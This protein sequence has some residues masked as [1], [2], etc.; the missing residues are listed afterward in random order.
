VSRLELP[1]SGL[2]VLSRLVCRAT[3][4]GRTTV[5]FRLVQPDAPRPMV[6]VPYRLAKDGGTLPG[7]PVFDLQPEHCH[8]EVVLDVMQGTQVL[9]R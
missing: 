7:S 4:Y 9:A 2:G 3:D 8:A 1:Q 5:H 6:D